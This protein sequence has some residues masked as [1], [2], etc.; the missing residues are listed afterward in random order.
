VDHFFDKQLEQSE[1]VDFDAKATGM[2]GDIWRW[3]GCNRKSVIARHGLSKRDTQGVS[4]EM[5]LIRPSMQTS[6]A[7][8]LRPATAPAIV[9]CVTAWFSSGA[10]LEGRGEPVAGSGGIR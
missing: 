4:Q 7:W 5:R 8:I 2:V 1:P 9:P 3:C 6:G 10:Y